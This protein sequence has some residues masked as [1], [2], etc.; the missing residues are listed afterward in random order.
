MWCLSTI[1]T[2]S[3]SLKRAIEGEEGGKGSISSLA[4]FVAS[5]SKPAK[6]VHKLSGV[7]SFDRDI[8]TPGLAFLAAQPQTELTTINVVPGFDNADLTSSD[9]VSS[10][11]PELVSSSYIGFIISSGY[12]LFFHKYIKKVI[13]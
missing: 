1:W 5:I 12:I 6:T 13:D 7:V 10:E 3:P 2:N 8:I 9:V 11:K 4:E